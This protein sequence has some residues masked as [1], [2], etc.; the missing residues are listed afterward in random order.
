MYRCCTDT[1]TGISIHAPAKGA[2]DYLL[3]FFGWR[4]FPYGTGYQNDLHQGLDMLQYEGAPVYSICNFKSSNIECGYDE[5]R[6]YYVNTVSTNNYPVQY[7]HLKNEVKASDITTY[8]QGTQLGQLGNTGASTG[9]HLHLGI[10]V[11]AVYVDPQLFIPV[12]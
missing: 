2:T 12:N 4:V 9:P 11:Y 5:S 8:T 7:M 3:G 1:E 6:G 10:I